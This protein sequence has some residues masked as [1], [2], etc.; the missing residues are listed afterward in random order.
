MLHV[1]KSLRNKW[2]IVSLFALQANVTTPITTSAAD[3]S[4]PITTPIDG[5]Q[6]PAP[7]SGPDANAGDPDEL[8][9]TGSPADYAYGAYQRGYYLTAMELALPRAEIGDPAA[10]TQVS[11]A[12]A[13]TRP[14][15]G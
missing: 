1:L 8:E 14:A 5:P 12:P 3:S 7:I 13:R 2:V 11:Q 9:S 4:A 10:Q 6:L 15:T